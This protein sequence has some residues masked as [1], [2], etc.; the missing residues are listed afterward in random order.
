MP[1][2]KINVKFAHYSSIP[3]H[4][5]THNSM[6][7]HCILP[8]LCSWLFQL[9]WFASTIVFSLALLPKNKA[10]SVANIACRTSLK[11]CLYSSDERCLKILCPSFYARKRQK[12]ACSVFWIITHLYIIARLLELRK[13]L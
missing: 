11:T 2:S 5:L 3:F 7:S 6:S 8:H 1:T 9:N 10:R 12:H 13:R 4:P